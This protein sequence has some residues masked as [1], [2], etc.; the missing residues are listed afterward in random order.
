MLVQRFSPFVALVALLAATF[1]SSSELHAGAS[2][3]NGNPYGNGTF[4]SDSGIYSAVVRGTNGFIGVIQF[5]T[6]ATNLSSTTITNTGMATVYAEGNQFIGTASGT[7]NAAA[8]TI[9]GT[10]SGNG[11]QVVTALPSL[12]GTANSALGSSGFTY[13]SSITN[14]ISSNSVAGSFTGNLVNQYPVQS[15]SGSGQATVQSLTATA[16]LVPE[17]ANSAAYYNYTP[18]NHI[19]NYDTTVNGNRITQ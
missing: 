6:D 9:Q 15:F 18:V 14:L 19:V 5:R 17:K 13:V 8:H 2:N 12:T 11:N 10:Y 16:T 7:V 3:K 1:L 4:F